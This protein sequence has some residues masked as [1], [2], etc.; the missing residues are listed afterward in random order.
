MDSE[1]AYDV[2]FQALQTDHAEL[3]Q[4]LLA[5][6]AALKLVDRRHIRGH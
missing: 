6:T 5:V 2:Y 3:Q 4:S 1:Y